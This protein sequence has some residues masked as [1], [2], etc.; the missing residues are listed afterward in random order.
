MQFCIIFQTNLQLLCW[1]PLYGSVIFSG[2][3]PILK[4]SFYF[5]PFLCQCKV[6][7][8]AG[9]S[10]TLFK[11]FNLSLT[12]LDA[13]FIFVV[14]V[15]VIGGLRNRVAG[16]HRLHWSS[17]IT[18]PE[19]QSHGI[20]PF[21]FCSISFL[22]CNGTVQL[23]AKLPQQPVRGRCLNCMIYWQ[24]CAKHVSQWRLNIKYL[25]YWQLQLTGAN[26]C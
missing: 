8:F 23:K 25:F 15:L 2:F 22:L 13:D 11:L 10:K 9:F 18:A 6:Q 21:S 26:S 7:C 14:G 16:V 20:Q 17:C 12:L 4:G 19:L 1:V 24:S 5:L 3:Y